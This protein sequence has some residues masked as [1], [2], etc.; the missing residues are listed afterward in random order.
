MEFMAWFSH[1]F[2]MHGIL[3]SLHKD[4]HQHSDGFFERNDSFFLM[5][6]IPSWLL[7]EHGMR[8]GND[9]RLFAG[10]GILAYGLTYFVFHEV[11][12]HQRFAW[13]RHAKH[14]Y[15]RAMRK[16]HYVHHR[17]KGKTGASCFG[18]LFFPRKYY[19]GE[20]AKRND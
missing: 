13:F 6:A 8:N 20:L 9:W 1:R 19:K 7:I 11:F 16:A 17:V 12:I 10:L 5:Y 4:H 18:L 14:P 2:I 15:F 3:W